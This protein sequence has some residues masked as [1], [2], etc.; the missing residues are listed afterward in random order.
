MWTI[1]LFS[2]IIRP[3]I[4]VQSRQVSAQGASDEQDLMLIV[5][6]HSFEHSVFCSHFE[7]HTRFHSSSAAFEYDAIIS[8]RRRA[9]SAGDAVRA[10]R[11]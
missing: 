2:S 4:Q 7:I 6:R 8:D 9:N 3:Q 11:D 1:Y 10:E 5:F